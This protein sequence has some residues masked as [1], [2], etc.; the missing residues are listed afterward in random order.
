MDLAKAASIG[1]G[2]LQHKN[3]IKAAISGLTEIGQVT[4]KSF[5]KIAEQF[6]LS[7]NIRDSIASALETSN[8]PNQT[9]GV[10]ALL[11]MG[12]FDTD[13]N[14]AISR[15]EL[16]EG[17]QKLNASGLA[18]KEGYQQLSSF[19]NKLLQHYDQAANLDGQ[20]A[21]FSYRDMGKLLQRDQNALALSD[22]DWQSLNA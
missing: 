14:G 15:T 7:K 8:N 1:M 22:S 6:G 18:N 2:V 10:Q 9:S 16:S 21:S 4:G 20:G 12:Y 5:S 11:A 13:K 3:E 17:L 19:G